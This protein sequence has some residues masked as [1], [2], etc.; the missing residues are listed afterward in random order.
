MYPQ[1][2]GSVN[3]VSDQIFYGFVMAIMFAM[4]GS[5]VGADSPAVDVAVLVHTTPADGGIVTPESGVHHFAL[6]SE[7]ALAA[8]AN[9]GYQFIQWLGD[10][11]EPAASRTV[12]YLNKPKIIIALFHKI[13]YELPEVDTSL[14]GIR[15]VGAGYGGGGSFRSAADFDQSTFSLAGGTTSRPPIISRTPT[16]EV[17]T[18]EWDNGELPEEQE[19]VEPIIPEPTTAALLAFGT[20]FSMHRLKQNRRRNSIK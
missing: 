18:G 7:V 11:R 2:G 4:G 14:V 8:T 15:A 10:V 16:A 17:D 20:L 1:G 13:G 3:S 6:N 5:A 19:P 9:P 12:S